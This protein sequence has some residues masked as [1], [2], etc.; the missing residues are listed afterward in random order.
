MSYS[1]D[2]EPDPSLGLIVILSAFLVGYLVGTAATL[3]FVLE[4][5]S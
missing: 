5:G 1:E 4:L 3:A 2:P